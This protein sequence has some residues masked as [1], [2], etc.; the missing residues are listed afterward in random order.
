MCVWS[1]EHHKFWVLFDDEA[2][3]LLRLFIKKGVHAER[4]N[5]SMLTFDC[6]A[7]DHTTMQIV[8]RF[9]AAI[10]GKFWKSNQKKFFG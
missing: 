10:S 7:F 9:F 3:W 8:C 2:P 4:D 5:R 6:P 1:I